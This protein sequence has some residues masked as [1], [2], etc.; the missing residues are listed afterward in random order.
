MST[1]ELAEQP[2][3]KLILKSLSYFTQPLVILRNYRRAD[4]VPDAFAGLSVAAVMLPQSFIYAIIA[5]M[6]PIAG[7][8]TAII[9]SI[10]AGLWGSSKH[11]QSGPTNT[12][13]LLTLSVAA[14]VAIPGAPEY[15]A[16]V[17]LLALMVGS[18]KM[19]V[20]LTRLGILA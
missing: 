16:A 9:G 18:F 17:A 1:L 19:L 3:S 10:V 5:G 6:P 14:T 11:A 20:G 12:H 8:Y 7:L 13:S 2:A 4:F 15:L